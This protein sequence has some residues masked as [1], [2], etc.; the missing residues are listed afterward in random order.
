MV[1]SF[2]GGWRCV[3]VAPPNALAAVGG[4][5][6][7]AFP[8]NGSMRSLAPFEATLERLG[9]RSEPSR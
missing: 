6:R 9:S 3:M 4:A 1:M 8:M 7:H 2:E 5:L